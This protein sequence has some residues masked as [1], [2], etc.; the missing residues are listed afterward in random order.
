MPTARDDAADRLA[1][2]TAAVYRVLRRHALAAE[3]PVAAVA[4]A[5]LAL[6][7]EAQQ[8]AGRPLVDLQTT[9]AAMWRDQGRRRSPVGAPLRK[10]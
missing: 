6:A 3:A 9:A 4:L 1:E 8:L 5:A 10:G 7:V 2:A